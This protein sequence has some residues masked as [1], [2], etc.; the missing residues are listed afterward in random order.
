MRAPANDE[1]TQE[2]PKEPQAVMLLLGT[3]AGTTWRM[4]IP[5]VGLLLVGDWVDRSLDTR[6]WLMLVGAGIG[7]AISTLLIRKQ[8]KG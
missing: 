4:F 2:P 6:P 3:I 7:A 5:I 1:R 8:L